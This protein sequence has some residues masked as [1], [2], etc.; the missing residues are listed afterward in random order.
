MF[1]LRLLLSCFLRMCLILIC[2]RVNVRVVLMFC[3]GIRLIRRIL[4]H[5][6]CLLLLLR[7]LLLRLLLLL[8][9]LLLLRLCR[10]R[11]FII[12]CLRRS[13]V[14]RLLLLL[15]PLSLSPVLDTMIMLWMR[16]LPFYLD[17]MISLF[18]RISELTL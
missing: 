13:I 16:P 8:L 1:L 18:G 2:V 9:L 17:V 6:L 5:M 15:V 10:L 7:L 14:V 11:R 3:L 4:V 12:V